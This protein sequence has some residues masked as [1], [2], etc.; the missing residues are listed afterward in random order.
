[1]R[2]LSPKTPF[3]LSSSGSSSSCHPLFLLLSSY[4][5]APHSFPR[6][7]EEESRNVRVSVWWDFENCNVPSGINVFKIS[8]TITAAIR[9]NG[10]KGPIE[11]TAFGDMVQLSRLKQ[12]A[13]SSTGINLTHIPSGGKNSADRSLLL[14]LMC[15]VSQNPPPAHLFLISGDRDFAS[16]LHRLRMNNYNILLASQE[17]APGVLCSA[18]S[19]MWHWHDLLRGE[20]LT[21]KY[22]NQPPDGPYGSWYGHYKVPLLNPFSDLEQ[23]AS[24]Q[25]EEPTEPSTDDKPRPV[26]K[27][28]L[29][30]LRQIVNSHPKG[31]TI[32]DLR[33]ELGKCNVNLGKD[34]Y[35]Y[36]RFVPFL[37]SQKNILR[38]K[39]EGD[40]HYIIRPII[41]RSPETLEDNTGVSTE[42]AGNNED[43]DLNSPSK[44]SCD[45]KSVKDGAERKTLPKSLEM[46][47]ISPP[48]DLNVKDTLGKAHKPSVDENMT[49]MVHKLE[50]ESHLP[51]GDEKNAERVKSPKSDSHM[52]PGEEKIIETVNGPEPKSSLSPVLEQDIPSEV[53]FFRKFWREWF[54]NKSGDFDNKT[55]NQEKSGTSADGSEEKSHTTSEKDFTSEIS[56]SKGKDEEKHSKS[57]A[58]F[59]DSEPPPS[60][61][62]SLNESALDN[63]TSTSSET[64]ENKPVR[65]P[66][67]LDRVRNWCKFWKSSSDSDYLSDRSPERPNLIIGHS[68]EQK[69]FLKDSFW[70]SMESFMETPK[71]SLLVSESR[72][73]E[74]L[75]HDLRREGPSCL[76][77]L[78]ENDLLHLVDL[79]ISEKNWVEE[80]PSE[81]FPFK[82]IRVAKSENVSHV[83]SS[84]FN[85]KKLPVRSRDQKLGFEKLASLLNTLS[86]VKIECGYVVPSDNT[87][88]IMSLES[89]VPDNQENLSHTVAS[90]SDTSN[91]GDGFDS[92][93]EELGPV[94]SSKSNSSKSGLMVRK[95]AVESV[96][97][98][99]DFDYEPALS[100]D[101]F[102]DSGD[103]STGIGAK[104]QRK[105]GQVKDS[106]SLLQILDSWYSSN[107]GDGFK[108]ETE[109]VNALL[110]FSKDTEKLSGL[111]EV[112]SK[113]ETS[114]K[115][116]VKKQ[117]P[118]KNY[119][120]VSDPVSHDNNEKLVDGILGNLR[121]SNESSKNAEV[122]V[123]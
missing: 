117:R 8:H 59:V 98:Q 63:R 31:L 106:S 79:L 49:K 4:S 95:S 45:E 5:S 81:A 97:K 114:L 72:T 85:K 41:Q 105:A 60:H 13:L 82:L 2:H 28:V 121:K 10:I 113:S 12:E 55:C 51:P 39:H 88:S 78:G 99:M 109:N 36:K 107:G 86:G 70:T 74:Q 17:S 48:T 66:G 71:G 90:N 75:A 52:P 18:A 104:G 47:S 35:G 32:T 115:S 67:F 83:D 77:S 110:D 6:R 65:S 43:E 22:F 40:G 14:N 122:K 56:F 62:L 102:S 50:S 57:T 108:D 44:L 68:E 33:H 30:K 123:L 58:P 3:L 25:I 101:E 29:N 111:S 27:A 92:L 11:I 34:Y 94:A 93:W 26:P 23:A 20:N 53:G 119:S 89:T 42:I 76:Q 91:K 37:L 118:Q 46:L 80:C 1:M 103:A 7:H 73:R 96:E 19:I 69:L 120:F 16:V 87:P 84:P 112:G 61:S 64:Y 54:G 38:I 100:D 116:Q 24:L 9:A 15:W 21:G